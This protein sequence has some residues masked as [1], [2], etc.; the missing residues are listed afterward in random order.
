MLEC[1]NCIDKTLLT[2]ECITSGTNLQVFKASDYY[3]YQLPRYSEEIKRIFSIV[4]VLYFIA[5]KLQLYLDKRDIPL[6]FLSTYDP[7]VNF[8]FIPN[9]GLH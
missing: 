2:L 8:L 5:D 1:S 6:S 9:V 7:W 4:Y 3:I